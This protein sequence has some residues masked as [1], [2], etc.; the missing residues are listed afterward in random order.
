MA[1]HRPPDLDVERRHT[2]GFFDGLLNGIILGLI[3]W[4]IILSL[5]FVLYLTLWS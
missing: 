2:F 1:H 5:V 3:G 4:G